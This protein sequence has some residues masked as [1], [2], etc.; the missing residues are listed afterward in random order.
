MKTKQLFSLLFLFFSLSIQAE[1]KLPQIIANNM[2]LQQQTQAKIWGWTTNNDVIN[3]TT[4]WDNISYKAIPQNGLWSVKVATPKASYQAYEITISDKKDKIKLSN[5]LIGEVWFCS[6]Q[7][8]MCLPVSG[9]LNQ[10]QEGSLNDIALSENNNIRMYTVKRKTSDTPYADTEG[11]W[12]IAHPSTTGKFS[13]VAYYFGSMLQKVTKYPIALIYCAWGGTPIEAW[14][15]NDISTPDAKV[16]LAHKKPSS[17]YNGMTHSVVGYSIKGAIW[18]QGE[19]N[20]FTPHKYP[21][22]FQAMHKDLQNKWDL[23]EFPFYL[24]QIAPYSYN[25][26]EIN[27]AFMREAQLKIAQTQKNTAIAILMDAGEERCIHPREKRKAGERLAYIALAK[28]YGYTT[29]QYIAPTYKSVKFEGRTAIL[30]F[31]NN[32]YGFDKKNIITEQFEVA[33]EDKVFHPATQ[34]KVINHEINVTSDKVKSPKAVRY[35]FKNYIKGALYGANNLP[36]SSF[37]T[38]DWDEVN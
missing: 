31:D 33:G 6:G 25:K 20:R 35:A 11:S 10:P 36:V 17:L 22:Q 12:E 21:A 2:I 24:C 15:S 32:E 1:I 37:R 27:S 7:S 34:V 26:N 18:Y 38:D 9:S 19:G 30:S 29:L 5:I 23:G 8:N 3:I 13:A 14:M 28:N 16:T 4:S